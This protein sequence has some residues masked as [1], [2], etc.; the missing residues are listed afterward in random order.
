LP[1]PK[2]WKVLTGSS[3]PSPST[4]CRSKSWPPAISSAA[5]QS[6]FRRLVGSGQ[7]SHHPGART[8]GLRRGYRVCYR[9][10]AALLADLTA[11]LAD[12]TLP[13]ACAITRARNSS[14]STS[15]GSIA[16]N[17]P[18]APGG[19]SL[20]QDHRWPQSET[21]DRLGD[22]CRLR[23]VG[24]LSVRRPLA[25]ALLDRLVQGAI[26]LK[27]KGRSYRATAQRGRQAGLRKPGSFSPH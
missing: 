8:A 11:S 27:I 10:S 3:I 22:E 24:R 25:M 16:S 15:S 9:T 20:L 7:E 17:A 6:D 4:G 13:S 14:S 18:R 5:G 19:S 23:Q 12:K 21:L 1:N 2:P 26:I